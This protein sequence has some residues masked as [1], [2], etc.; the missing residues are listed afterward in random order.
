MKTVHHFSEL[1]GG[2]STGQSNLGVFNPEQAVANDATTGAGAYDRGAFGRGNTI[3][4]SEPDPQPKMGDGKFIPQKNDPPENRI[5]ALEN[6]M[7]Q[8][9]DGIA[10]I[11]QGMTTMRQEIT[12][13]VTVV[14]QQE[15]AKLGNQ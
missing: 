12:K 4:V 7:V 14:I 9:V 15:I 5:D 3:A 2:G 1:D 6:A 11:Q 10:T 8:V 13:D